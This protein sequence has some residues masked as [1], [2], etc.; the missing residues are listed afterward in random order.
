MQ[1]F[2]LTEHTILFCLHANNTVNNV[3]AVYLKKKETATIKVTLLEH[4]FLTEETFC[5]QNLN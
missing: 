3:N 4:T 2:V 5:L 1:F